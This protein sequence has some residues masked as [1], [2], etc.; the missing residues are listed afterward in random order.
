MRWSDA[1]IG[2]RADR[3]FK[4]SRPWRLLWDAW[5]GVAPARD[6]GDANGAGMEQVYTADEITLSVCDPPEATT[7][8]SH[9][10]VTRACHGA[11]ARALPAPAAAAVRLCL[12][13]VRARP[14]PVGV[15]RSHPP[16]VGVHAGSRARAAALRRVAVV[17]PADGRPPQC[18]GPRRPP[19]RAQ[20]LP[21][22][23]PPL[24]PLPHPWARCDYARLT[25][26]QAELARMRQ[27]D[28]AVRCAVLDC[29]SQPVLCAAWL[30]EPLSIMHVWRGRHPSGQS[31]ATVWRRVPLGGAGDG[32][33]RRLRELRRTGAWVDGEVW[34]GFL[35]PY[36]GALGR[37]GAGPVW[38]VLRYALDRVP[39][40]LLALVGTLLFRRL[41]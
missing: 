2:Q 24:P 6:D 19:R 25:L 7:Y 27:A 39:P 37:W 14:A 15:P 32:A 4:D 5:R 17:D 28:P 13:H 3:Q 29:R 22:P 36:V 1:L 35:H 30:A 21:L 9:L 40:W 11:P 34:D 33:L 12:P 31:C 16:H 10:F 18:L 23:H 20:L 26:S 38:G 8:L 41:L